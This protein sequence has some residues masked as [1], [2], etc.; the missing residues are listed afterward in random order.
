MN[1]DEIKAVKD[2]N[3]KIYEVKKRIGEGGQGI[4]FEVKGGKQA[5]KLIR[6]SSS[7]CREQLRTKLQGVR[8]LE[9][10]DLPIAKPLQMLAKPNVGY[11]MELYTGMQ[12]LSKLIF[13]GKKINP[14]LFY[15]QT[16]GLKRRLEVLSKVAGAFL[17]MHGRSLIY[18]DPS[19][20]NIFISEDPDFSEIRLIDSDNIQ[21]NTSRESSSVYTPRYGAP[22]L[23]LG[24]TPANTLTD[25]YAFAVIVFETLTYIHPLL[26]DQILDG[27]PEKEEEAFKGGYPWIDHST[28]RTNG[29]IRGLE[30]DNT[31]SPELMKLCSETF[32][33]GLLIPEKRPGISKW[34]DKL[35][36]ALDNTL[37]CPS[38]NGSFY[39]NKKECPWCSDE[40][41][42]QYSPAHVLGKIGRWEP[43]SP[44][45]KVN[46]TPDGG[47][48]YGSIT[49]QDEIPASIT[50]RNTIIDRSSEMHESVLEIL[51]Y[52]VKK[53]L[54]IRATEGHKVWISDDKGT[55]FETVRNDW[56]KINP[57]SILHFG[58]KSKSHR[59]LY[60]QNPE[61][62][63]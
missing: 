50:K 60:F 6:S 25:I 10:E 31:L 28:D 63:K 57:F 41:D 38:C 11:V 24:K 18:G 14:L 58:H 53:T 8:R 35:Y 46:F 15:I 42:R 40:N 9:I 34:V 12:P 43:E 23:V 26:G 7:I 44:S 32:E 5:I 22:E 49:L 3:G 47:K 30:R 36:S 37:S 45:K 16:G 4:V 17:K 61:K 13:P 27:E 48:P 55:T 20:N 54:L 59:F 33:D 56:V 51:F 52:K 19:P 1:L 21:F 39:R 29:T 2:E 62:K